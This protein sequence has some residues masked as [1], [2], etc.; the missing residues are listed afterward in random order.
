[1]IVDL[2]FPFGPS[3]NDGVF[4][5]LSFISYSSVDDV[6]NLMLRMGNGFIYVK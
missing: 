4:S 1:M 3:V 6:V 2:S 5:K